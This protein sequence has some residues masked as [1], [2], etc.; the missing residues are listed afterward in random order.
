[1]RRILAERIFESSLDCT[2]KCHLLLNGRHGTK[3][4][5]EEHTER[6][7]GMY[8]RAAIDRLQEKN[9]EKKTRY[10]NKLPRQQNLWVS[11]GSGNCPSH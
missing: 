5:Y 8:R 3:T 1:M 2:Y 10:L 6:F 4:E 9:P 7:D 11:G